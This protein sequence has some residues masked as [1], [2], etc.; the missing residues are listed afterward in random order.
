MIKLLIDNSTCQIQG[1]NRKQLS[2]L[3]ELMCYNVD[4]QF[5]YYTKTYHTIKK[6]LITKTGHFPTGLLY[7][8]KKWIKDSDLQSECIDARNPPKRSRMPYKTLFLKSDLTPYPEQ[9]NAALVC[10]NASNEGRGIISAPTGSGKSLI[11][12]LIIDKIQVK[13][14]IVVPSL[15]LKSQL[16]L[17]LSDWF[18]NKL[19]G[20]LNKNGEADK[21][22][23]IENVDA[24]DPKKILKG[25][26]MVL[27]DEF[28]HSASAT[29][30]KLNEKAW[31]KVYYRFG[32]TAT[33]FRSDDNERLLLESV[34]SKIIYKIYYTTAVE[35]K[36]IVPVEA[37]YV[38]IPRSYTSST[39]WAGVYSDLVVNNE[40]RNKIIRDILLKFY[41]GNAATLCLVKEIDHGLK[42]L[43]QINR[44][45]NNDP[46]QFVHGECKDGID[47]FNSG[48][49]ISLIGTYGVLGEGI[50]T[51]PAEFV[52][53]AGL[54]KSKNAFMQQVGRCLRTYPGKE[55]GKVIIFSDS[56][57]KW[58]RSHFSEQCKILLDEY[59][60][61]PIRLF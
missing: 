57:H 3:K 54:G 55:S 58:T 42:I 1:L 34:L 8:A 13:T 43:T 38:E 7:I 24:L 16:T 40:V 59:G 23:T 19:V 27:I 47:S 4:N 5:N 61:T 39:K 41:N 28:H 10:L 49:E 30:R 45:T 53:I 37:Y 9:T 51:K 36:Y 17:T 46:T 32:L 60:V 22:I 50:D 18:G 15:S 26:D 52:I 48:Q 29:Y 14:L 56:S 35:K 33:P 2:E 31:S 6:Y 21:F 11:T 44:V 25:V 12:A 20:S